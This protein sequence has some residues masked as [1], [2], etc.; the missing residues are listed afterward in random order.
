MKTIIAGSRTITHY[1][2]VENAIKESGFEIT[3]VVSGMAR[4]V[5]KLG[6]LWAHYNNIG[7]YLCPADWNRYGK[8]AGYRRNVDMANIAEALIVIIENNS[9]GSSHML[10]IAKERGLKIFEKHI[11]TLP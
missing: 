2:T 1:D 8:S 9:K 11:T 6:E 4:G 3:Q 10:N 7:C 5:D